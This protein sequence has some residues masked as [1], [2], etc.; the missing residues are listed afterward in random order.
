MEDIAYRIRQLSQ[1][2]STMNEYMI[3]QVDIILTEYSN[4]DTQKCLDSLQEL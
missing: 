4:G 2:A 3:T 1:I